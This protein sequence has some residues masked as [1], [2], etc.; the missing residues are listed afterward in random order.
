MSSSSRPT[1]Q[2]FEIRPEEEQAGAIRCFI[3]EERRC[4]R[5]RRKESL[6]AS[7]VGP[8]KEGAALETEAS[9]TLSLTLGRTVELAYVGYGVSD[10]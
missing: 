2:T 8:V 6:I 3:S 10:T 7:E 5:K 1:D 9:A 4:R